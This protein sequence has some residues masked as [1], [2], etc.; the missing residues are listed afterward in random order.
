MRPKWEEQVR[1][2]YRKFFEDRTRRRR[3]R[4]EESYGAA[5]A[6]IRTAESFEVCEYSASWSDFSKTARRS[7]GD[8]LRRL[9]PV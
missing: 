5:A 6:K 3:A 7:D 8:E 1:A 4:L 2:N 9:F